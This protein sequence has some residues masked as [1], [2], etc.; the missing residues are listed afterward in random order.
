MA[1]RER[2]MIVQRA[3]VELSDFA[4]KLREQHG[5]SY[6]EYLSILNQEAAR[7][8]KFALRDERKPDDATEVDGVVWR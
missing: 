2:I 7:V 1:D 6:L 3:G 4:M 5:L 8:L